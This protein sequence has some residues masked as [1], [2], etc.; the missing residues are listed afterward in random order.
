MTP[1]QFVAGETP[2]LTRL[3]IAKR[4]GGGAMPR[5]IRAS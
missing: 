3:T 1:G 5:L 2:W 4:S